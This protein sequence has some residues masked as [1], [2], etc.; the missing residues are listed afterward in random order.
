[1]KQVLEYW[2]LMILRRRWNRWNRFVRTSCCGTLQVRWSA[3]A[4]REKKPSGRPATQP[5]CLCLPS[6]FFTSSSALTRS[7]SRRKLPLR[8]GG[9]RGEQLEK[10]T[11]LAQHC[12]S[13]T[14]TQLCISFYRLDVRPDSIDSSCSSCCSCSLCGPIGRRA[15]VTSEKRTT[16]VWLILNEWFTIALFFSWKFVISYFEMA[17]RRTPIL[18]A[19]D[20]A[21]D[22]QNVRFW[23]CM[24][25]MCMFRIL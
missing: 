25:W 16:N 14:E 22:M 5:P 23:M 21:E 10:H 3:A 19:S 12:L 13:M 2:M 8:K 7:S 17:E 18:K 6:S 24:F 11:I 4:V 1:M 15:N 9:G 20:M